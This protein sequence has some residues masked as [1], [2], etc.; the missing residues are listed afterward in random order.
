MKKLILGDGLLGSFLQK[1]TGWDYISREKNNLNFSNIDSYKNYLINYDE[2]I[3][4]IAHTDT[5]SN[6]KELHWNVNYKGVVELVDYCVK[7]NKKLIHISTDYIYS[8]S[9]NEATEDD[10]P[11]HCANWYGYTKLLADGYVQLKMNDYLLIRTTH[12]KEPFTYEYAYINQIGNFDYISVIGNL[13]IKLINKNSNGVFN[14]GTDIK[15]MYDIAK[16][17]KS[18]VKPTVYLINPTTPNNVTMNIKK[19]NKELYG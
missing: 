7:N 16:K 17:T 4:C 2:I 1:E 12:K 5:Y 9:K 14:V 19:M 15:T 10:V 3:N 6:N 18:D 11:V 13:I 8:F